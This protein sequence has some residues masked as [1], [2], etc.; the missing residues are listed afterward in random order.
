LFACLPAT[1]SAARFEQICEAAHAHTGPALIV[2]DGSGVTGE[3]AKGE[4]E[5]GRTEE[6]KK[7]K[8]KKKKKADLF[9]RTASFA[10]VFFTI[11]ERADLL[12]TVFTSVAC[13]VS[14][15]VGRGGGG[16]GRSDGHTLQAPCTADRP[17]SKG[18]AGACPP[19]FRTV[20]TN[21]GRYLYGGPRVIRLYARARDIS[22]S[23]LLAKSFSQSLAASRRFSPLLAAPL[24]GDNVV[25]DAR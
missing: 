2:K 13:N 20:K 19:S 5:E 21:F 11:H 1:S 7:K 15:K 14:R 4:H 16:R 18:M 22:P 25:N 23:A 10:F 12:Q 6:K 8:K 3:L 17:D 24:L 9:G